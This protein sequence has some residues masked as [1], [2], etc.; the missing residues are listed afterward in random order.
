MRG[1]APWLSLLPYVLAWGGIVAAIALARDAWR[2]ST[3]SPRAHLAAIALA[4]LALQAVVH[5]ISGKFEHPHYQNGT[6]ISTV[7]L[8]WLAVDALVRRPS[9][10]RL[11]VAVTL[12]VLMTNGASVAS[13]AWRLHEGRGTRNAEYGP[14][15][16]EQQTVARLLAPLAI[17]SPLETRVDLWVRFP[18]TLQTLR[19]LQPTP[20][21]ERPRANIVLDYASV[22]PRRADVR[23][24]VR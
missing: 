1:K 12:L 4:S 10:R 20:P 16:A 23:V 11:A 7:L 24:I 19:T 17:D 18:D 6:W 8:T 13:V 3:W 15:L 9:T 21:G 2:T 14:T 22:D 5:G